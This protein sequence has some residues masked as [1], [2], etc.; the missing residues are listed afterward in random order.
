M[1]FDVVKKCTVDPIGAKDFGAPSEL[2]TNLA[3]SGR[4]FFSY[5]MTAFVIKRLID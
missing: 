1:C 5:M 2:L 3:N 4:Y